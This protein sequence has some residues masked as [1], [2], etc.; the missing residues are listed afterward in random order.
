[1]GTYDEYRRRAQKCR[2]MADK[3][4]SAADKEAWLQLADSWLQMLTRETTPQNWPNPSGQDSH[5]LH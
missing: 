2:G 3:A 4:I 1:M 5:E